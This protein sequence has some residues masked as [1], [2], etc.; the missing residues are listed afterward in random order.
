MSFNIRMGCGHS[1]PFSLPKGSLGYLPKCAEVI[2]KHNPDICGIQE[3]DR[4]SKRAGFMDQAFEL[5]KLSGMESSWVEKI[6]NYGVATLFKS[7]PFCVSKVLMKGSIHTRAL[8]INEYPDC[9]I[10]NTH[11]PLSKATRIEA[12]KT[13]CASL[14]PYAE[15]KPVFVMGD[16][17]AKPDSET[18]KIFEKDFKII[19]DVSLPTFPAKSPKVTIDYIMVDKAHAQNYKNVKAYVDAV[20]EATDHAA[21]IV[22]LEY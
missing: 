7:R 15:K 19:S 2:R 10:A 16:I 6:K 12:A 3:V 20:P 5:G 17:N 9:V 14:K 4:N 13:V 11:F 21:I 22:E 1:D 18:I 8:M